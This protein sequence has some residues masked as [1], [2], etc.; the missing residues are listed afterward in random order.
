[1]TNALIAAKSSAFI[2][3]FSPISFVPAFPG[4]IYNFSILGLWAI[5]QAKACSRPPEPNN[6][7]FMY[8]SVFD[9]TLNNPQNIG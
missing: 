8:I 6:N 5:F 2:V 7:N 9:F 3:T 4:A 1:M